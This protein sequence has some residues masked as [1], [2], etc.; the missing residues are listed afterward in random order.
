MPERSP[1]L[2]AIV[3]LDEEYFL[4]DKQFSS[5]V[6]SGF[7]TYSTVSH[8]QQCP[9]LFDTVEDAIADMSWEVAHDPSLYAYR[10][11]RRLVSTIEVVVDDWDRDQ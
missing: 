7:N 11:K 5:D 9:D 6:H 8:W 4:V 2:N 1:P 10:I 3:D